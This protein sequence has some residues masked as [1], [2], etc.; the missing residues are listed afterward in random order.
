MLLSDMDMQ[1]TQL[2]VGPNDMEAIQIDMTKTNSARGGDTH[3]NK[4]PM[5]SG[6][7]HYTC[8]W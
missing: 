5:Q 2:Y 3:S 6:I 1:Q 7:P 8:C 4:D